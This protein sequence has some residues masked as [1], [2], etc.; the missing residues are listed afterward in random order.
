M[1]AEQ[2]YIEQCK[3]L[4]NCKN[5]SRLVKILFALKVFNILHIK[6]D[7]I[8]RLSEKLFKARNTERKK[9]DRSMNK[10]RMND[11]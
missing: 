1:K 3:I 8:K 2:F 10:I 9:G 5:P 4:A 6:F 7:T 11:I